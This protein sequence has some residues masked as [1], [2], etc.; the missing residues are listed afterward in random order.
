[1]RKRSFLFSLFVC[2]LSLMLVSSCKN[3][4]K[5]RSLKEMQDDF[6]RPAEMTLAK[7]DTDQ[8]K[9]LVQLYLSHLKQGD[10]DGALSMLYYLNK[11][12]ITTLPADLAKKERM[13]LTAF[14]GKKAS[15]EEIQFLKETDSKV[16]YTVTLFDKAPG[17]KRP[18]TISFVIRPVRRDGKWYLTLADSATETQQSQLDN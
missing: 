11:D 13:T 10:V 15:V 4:P 18:N 17:D 14:K 16:R 3:K 5:E 6:I 12:S 9:S 2:L 8:V 7:S 1:M